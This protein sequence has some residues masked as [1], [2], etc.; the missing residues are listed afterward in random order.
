MHC[1]FIQP[2]SC[3]LAN[4]SYSPLRYKNIKALLN[5]KSLPNKSVLVN[6]F[7]NQHKLDFRSLITPSSGVLLDAMKTSVIKPVLKSGVYLCYLSD[8]F[9]PV[10]KVI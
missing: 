8:V 5:V 10:E 4:L 6:D 9:H 7:I 3:S 2:D 1:D